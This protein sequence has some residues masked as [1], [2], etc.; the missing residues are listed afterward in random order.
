MIFPDPLHE[1]ARSGG[2]LGSDADAHQ[3]AAAQDR[4]NHATRHRGCCAAQEHR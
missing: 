4:R 3:G 1:A 2:H